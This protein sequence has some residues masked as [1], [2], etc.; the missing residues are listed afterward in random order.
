MATLDGRLHRHGAFHAAIWLFVKGGVV[1]GDAVWVFWK[2]VF[3]ALVGGFLA[4]AIRAESI[5]ARLFLLALSTMAT[6]FLTLV[7]LSSRR[8]ALS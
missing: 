5:D 6:I 8:R 4:A 7:T 2:V 1:D 3:G